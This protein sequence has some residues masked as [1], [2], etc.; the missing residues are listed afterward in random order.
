M[1]NTTNTNFWQRYY[2]FPKL[3]TIIAVILAVTGIVCAYASNM[4]SDLDMTQEEPQNITNEDLKHMVQN[5]IFFIWYAFAFGTTIS[6][7]VIYL[8][9]MFN[10]KRQYKKTQ[11]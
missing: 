1:T 2:S 10:P 9:C 7:I 11:I 6:G 5:I 3:I 4:I 8:F